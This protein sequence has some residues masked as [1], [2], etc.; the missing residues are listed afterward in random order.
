[1]RSKKPAAA[2]VTIIVAVGAVGTAFVLVAG[3]PATRLPDHREPGLPTFQVTGFAQSTTTAAQLRASAATLT[4]VSIV[5][6]SLASDGSTLSAITDTTHTLRRDA[7]SQGERVEMLVN[8]FDPALQAFSHITAARMLQSEVNRSRVVQSIAAEVS[9]HGWDGVTVDLE[10]LHRT[11]TDGLTRFVTQL[12]EAV[13][14][15]ISISLCLM[16]EQQDYRDR[17]Y[18]LPALT[19][20]VDTFVLMAYEQHGPAWSGPGPIGGY[21]WVRNSLAALLGQVP[22][23]QV[24]LGI[25]GYAYLWPTRGIGT[26]YSTQT[27]RG[28]ARDAGAVPRWSAAEQEWTATLASG[29][30][31]WWSDERSFAARLR[32]AEV[33]GLGGVAL[34]SL[35]QADPIE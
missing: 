15:G 4:S 6:S 10:N 9:R 19:G 7:Q 5:A 2:L 20:Q 21:P 14:P 22:A 31:L 34:W 25:G 26:V 11:E 18:D 29:T 32:L 17:G 13:G 12:R 33:E 35:D 28:I 30:Q 24:Q 8:N 23:A 16:V 3:A 1:M 27:A